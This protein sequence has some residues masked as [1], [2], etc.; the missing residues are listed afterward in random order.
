[1]ASDGGIEMEEQI[2]E[3][4]IINRYKNINYLEK[5]CGVS[6]YKLIKYREKLRNT[7]PKIAK[8]I[9][10]MGFYTEPEIE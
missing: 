8:L 4:Y 5:K 9:F 3:E 2:C 1:M 7:S 6:K 10:E